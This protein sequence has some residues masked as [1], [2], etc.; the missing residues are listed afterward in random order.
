MPL[1]K[2]QSSKQDAL[3]EVEAIMMLTACRDLLDN[4]T[5]RLPLYTGMRIGEVRWCSILKHHGLIGKKESSLYL[6]SR[7]AHVMSERNGE[8]KFGLLRL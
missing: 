2:I 1:N 5:V 7:N 4:L 6:P 3:N 8:I